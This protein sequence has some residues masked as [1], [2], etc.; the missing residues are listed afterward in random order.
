MGLYKDTDLSTNKPHISL[1]N[2]KKEAYVFPENIGPKITYN[3]D[4]KTKG[5]RVNFRLHK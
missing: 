5:R 2:G 1:Q 4:K 3:Q